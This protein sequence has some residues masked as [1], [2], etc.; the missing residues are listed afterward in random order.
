MKNYDAII[1][2][3]GMG[4]IAAAMML[5]HKGKKVVVFEKNTLLGGRLSSYKKDGFTLDI[6]VHVISRGEKGPV[7]ECLS[8]VGIENPIKFIKIRPLVSFNGKPFV[9]PHDLKDMVAEKDFNSLMK[10]MSD[11]MTYTEEQISELDQI[12]LKELLLRYTDNE[13]IHTVVSR[14]GS[15]YCG[16]PAW[17]EA[18]GEFVRCMSWE[19]KA[20]A[21]GYPEGGC[22]A[23]TNAFV[24]GI[25]TF[26]GEVVNN[27]PVEKIIVENGRAVG[28]IVGGKTYKAEMIISNA[29]I[30]NT[31]LNL[32]DPGTFAAE[33]VEYVKNLKYAWAGPVIR[34]ALD[35][36]ITDLKML[37][38]FGEVGQEQYFDKIRRGVMPEQLNLFLV[39]PSNFSP[40]VAPEGKQ[41]INV[42]TPIPTDTSQEVIDRLQ[43]AMLDT[44]EKYI[45]DLRKHIMWTDFMSINACAGL[46]G[47]DGCTIGIAQ[48]PGQV[49]AKRPK[50]KT[51]LEGLYIVGCDCGGAGVG[52]ELAANSAL[53]FIDNYC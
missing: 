44:A 17:V 34:I 37:A 35:Q 4:G 49:G 29:D 42:A 6:G 36:K 22:V 18:A 33:Y 12:T 10:F 2:G 8:R 15:I 7:V 32:I 40:V 51:P 16:I 11:V 25:K 26:G 21:S 41:L 39:V 46:A 23:I 52:I 20:R 31:V 14:I 24:E 47:E 50:I 28:V 48:S 27:S 43:E 19:A 38:Q 1:I 9:F 5:A 3:S 45:P 13:V 53:E 30:R